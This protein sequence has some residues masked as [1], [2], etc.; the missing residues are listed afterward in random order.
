MIV[1]DKC[2]IPSQSLLRRVRAQ[3]MK[4]L[5]ARRWGSTTSNSTTKPF[6]HERTVD[7]GTTQSPYQRPRVPR[8]QK[9]HDGCLSMKVESPH[10]GPKVPRRQLSPPV[11][12][13]ED[14]LIPEKNCRPSS[15][16][17][18]ESPHAQQ[19]LPEKSVRTDKGPLQA[20]ASGSRISSLE[21]NLSPM[22]PSK[23]G[24][25]H[26]QPKVR[27][28]KNSLLAAARKQT[29]MHCLLKNDSESG[30]KYAP[31]SRRTS[32]AKRDGTQLQNGNFEPQR[33]LHS[34]GERYS[35]GTHKSSVDGLRATDPLRQPKSRIRHGVAIRISSPRRHKFSIYDEM[36]ATNKVAEE[37]VSSC[38]STPASAKHRFR[39]FWGEF[40]PSR[41]ARSSSF[42]SSTHQ[43][44]KERAIEK[45]SMTPGRQ[46]S[47][48]GLRS[49]FQNL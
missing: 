33:R 47:F 43:V 30:K 21:L 15:S 40:R 49:T 44:S 41:L 45:A 42:D 24:C 7:N 12:K 37:K 1:E 25:K 10:E 18:N 4:E 38:E 5:S 36:S 26:H 34:S 11:E 17:R 6:G 8:R 9:S 29:D 13:R 14:S 27:K 32:T 39:R 23:S 35:Q 2:A 46:S 20:Q 19:R 48:S 28:Q 22:L 16:D 3:K 31:N